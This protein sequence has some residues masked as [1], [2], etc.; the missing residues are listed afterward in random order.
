ML[1]LRSTDPR[2]IGTW[3][4][5]GR[6]GEGGQGV[7]YLAAKGEERA[8][9]KVFK[10]T[11][12]KFS[13]KELDAARRVS[14]SLSTAKILE[15]GRFEDLTYIA[16][17]YVDGP[18]LY[19]LVA[20]NGPV[21]DKDLTRLVIGTITAL[22]AIHKAGVVHRDFKP[23]NVLIGPDGPVVIDFGVAHIMQSGGTTSNVVGTPSYAA[24]EQL[25]GEKAAAPADIFAWASTICYA[26]TGRPAFGAD[27]IPAVMHRILSAPPN[28]DGIPA[29]LR[30][31]LE[32]CLNKNPAQRPSAHDLVGYLMTLGEGA[33]TVLPAADKALAAAQTLIHTRVQP[34]E[35]PRLWWAHKRYLAIAAGLA[36]I[37]LAAALA[38]PTAVGSHAQRDMASAGAPSLVSARTRDPSL[39]AAAGHVAPKPQTA[40]DYS[41]AIMAAISRQKGANFTHELIIPQ[42]NGISQSSGRLLYSPAGSTNYDMTVTFYN[43]ATTQSD[44]AHALVIGNKA[45]VSGP[46]NIPYEETDISP[47]TDPTNSDGTWVARD[48][49]WVTSPYN[50][51]ELLDNATAFTVNEPSTGLTI[52]KGHEPT[53]GLIN[54]P[55]GGLFKEMEIAPTTNFTISL[56]SQYLPTRLEMTFYV[57]SLGGSAKAIATYSTWG[58]DQ[59]PIKG[60]ACGTYGSAMNPIRMYCH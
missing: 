60:P 59:S 29:S 1:K 34:F 4:V 24:P 49:R 46:A 6:L 9:I 50:F 39:T 20:K 10:E 11:G 32:A 8:A 17:E 14:G 22:A 13:V 51:Q 21:T 26:A 41:A 38:W 57:T 56:N 27:S 45:Y 36:A 54:G 5:I 40:A 28:L 12:S 33:T 30:P 2:Q 35:Q 42:G 19:G 16:T 58:D 31:T 25:A 43:S 18:D 15:T 3:E 47:G 55:T 52:L 48:A 37:S 44:Q 53:R 23:S 7:V